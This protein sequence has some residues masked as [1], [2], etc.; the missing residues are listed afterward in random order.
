MVETLQCP[1]LERKKEQEKIFKS[2]NEL[3][4]FELKNNCSK[5]TIQ[6]KLKELKQ[7]EEE[8]KELKEQEKLFWIWLTEDNEIQARIKEIKNWLE[9]N[10]IKH[11]V[12]K[13]DTLWSICEKYYKN[14]TYSQILTNELWYKIFIIP[15]QILYLPAERWMKKVKLEWEGNLNW[16][17][18]WN[19]IE[20]NNLDW[21]TT[22]I[23]GLKQDKKY[24]FQYNQEN[25]NQENKVDLQQEIKRKKVDLIKQSLKNYANYLSNYAE[26]LE[27]VV[28]WRQNWYNQLKD[29]S[30]KIND[31]VENSQSIDEILENIENINFSDETF[32]QNRQKLVDTIT[33]ILK[34]NLWEKEAKTLLIS[35]LRE[36]DKNDDGIF[37]NNKVINWHYE[38]E[39][40]NLLLPEIEK[41]DVISPKLKTIIEKINL[42]KQNVKIYDIIASFVKP[43]EKEVKYWH[44]YTRIIK[45]YSKF[46]HK[47][48]E[49]F[50][51]YEITRKIH[52]VKNKEDLV[53]KY[54]KQILE[55]LLPE[56][57]EENLKE[58]AKQ[59][60]KEYERKFKKALTEWKSKLTEEF[61]KENGYKLEE[62]YVNHHWKR[63]KYRIVQIEKNPKIPQDKIKEELR[64]KIKEYE[65]KAENSK[66]SYKG[67]YDKIRQTY[68]TKIVPN[69][70]IKQLKIKL[71]NYELEHNLTEEEK[72]NLAKKNKLFEIYKDEYWIWIFD[73]SDKNEQ[74]SKFLLKETAIQI[75]M[76][77][78]PLKWS[79]S[80]TRLL[81]KKKIITPIS[82]YENINSIFHKWVLRTIDYTIHWTAFSIPYYAF[83]SIRQAKEFGE[84]TDLYKEQ[85]TN[86]EDLIKNVIMLWWMKYLWEMKYIKTAEEK[87]IKTYEI[88]TKS[89]PNLENPHLDSKIIWSLYWVTLEAGAIYSI[90]TWINFVFEWKWLTKED[91]VFGLAMVLWLRLTTKAEELVKIV[92]EDGK[93]KLKLVRLKKRLERTPKELFKSL[94]TNEELLKIRKDS[95]NI[96]DI[97]ERINEKYL[98]IPKEQILTKREIKDIVYNELISKLKIRWKKLNEL[99]KAKLKLLVNI[100]LK[101]LVNNWELYKKVKKEGKTYEE[102]KNR[103]KSE[104]TINNKFKYTEIQARLW[105]TVKLD[106]WEKIIEDILKWVR[107]EKIDKRTD[108][109]V[110]LKIEELIQIKYLEKFNTKPSEEEIVYY[111]DKLWRK[112]EAM[113]REIEQ[114]NKENK[115]FEEKIKELADKLEKLD[116]VEYKE[117]IEA[118]RKKVEDKNKMKGESKNNNFNILK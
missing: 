96:W 44:N 95:K 3:L 34:W 23:A 26:N 7:L 86:Y 45:D 94:I 115:N 82:E 83:T 73:M 116:K 43:E 110:L 17:K 117:I 21:N 51:S 52:N 104:D 79:S 76:M 85:I 37:W 66:I 30:E 106:W 27:F 49:N 53:I 84:I 99:E 100:K 35:T 9:E 25:N 20:E 47:L 16:L 93:I 64:K 65:E 62:Y 69:E 4:I 102:F 36:I 18:N 108:A 74:L 14:W 91:F 24:N 41:L 72:N 50:W 101:Q 46:Y 92:K 6:R 15:G 48:N 19:R 109:Y 56:D 112:Y 5:N 67:F 13:W 22:R 40:D 8:L 12:K 88:K 1:T 111:R 38:M 11:I 105:E 63:K 87:L 89:N 55:N 75:A 90:W 60:Y 32:N 98:N 78:L 114:V 103:F 97:M 2:K 31:I 61:L 10:T 113:K 57:W 42:S 81:A 71:I 39:I 107:W 33:T 59:M 118:L 58:T 68:I 54:A 29:F 70:F 80:F 28:L 77:Y